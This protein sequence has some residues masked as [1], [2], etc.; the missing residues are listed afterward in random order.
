ME[1]KNVVVDAA[2]CLTKCLTSLRCKCV[3]GSTFNKVK[4]VGLITVNLFK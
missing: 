1:E 2:V 4:D 3:T